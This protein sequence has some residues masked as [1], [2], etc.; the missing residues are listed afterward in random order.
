VDTLNSKFSAEGI[1]L[2][3][4]ATGEDYIVYINNGE[5]TMKKKE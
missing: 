1:I 2:K 4:Q 5:L 3:D